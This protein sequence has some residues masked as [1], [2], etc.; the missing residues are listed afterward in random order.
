MNR[1][2][3]TSLFLVAVLAPLDGREYSYGV[4]HCKGEAK[5]KPLTRDELVAKYRTCARRVLSE[6]KVERSIEII[7][8]LENVNTIDE[9][10]ETVTV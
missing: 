1:I 8:Q 10:M 6:N 3:A 2:L 4:E 9:L 7:D 5:A